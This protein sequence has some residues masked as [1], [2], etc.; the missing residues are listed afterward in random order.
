MK[1][2]S[3]NI[4]DVA[5]TVAGMARERM[6]DPKAMWGLPW[7]FPGLNTLTGGIHSPE[8]TVLAA[9]PSVGKTQIMV[10]TANSVVKFLMSKEGKK[11]H[12]DGV[13]K[14]VLCESSANVFVRRWACL[15]S[16]VPAR[17]VMDGSI[18]QFPDKAQ[19]FFDEVE[20]IGR[21]P[22]EFKDNA[23]SLDE[24]VTFLSEGNTAWWALDYIQKCPYQPGRPND[25]SVGPITVI[26]G[27]LTE[28]ARKVAPGLALA[29]TPRA[30]DAREDRRPR[31]G[32]LK[33]ASSLEGDARV[34]LGL[35]REAIYHK[36]APEE[37]NKPQPAELL[38]LKN[39]EG[40][41]VGRTIDLLFHPR[42]GIFEDVSETFE[43]DYGDD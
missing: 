42:R 25:G 16:G 22:V 37:A 6:A 36:I 21:I 10:Q 8:L 24:V 13:V 9:R 11:Q 28:V 20:K 35:Y 26:S 5:S 43:E 14:L 31:M 33:G 17:R 40:G 1:P 41:G 3:R 19:A 27:A 34:V 39:N 38:I 2:T 32:D 18:S 23:R 12:P 30:V 7:P 15:R 4:A 29:H